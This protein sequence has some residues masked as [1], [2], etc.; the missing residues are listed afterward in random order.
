[1]HC[2][3]PDCVDALIPPSNNGIVNG[4]IVHRLL[5]SSVLGRWASGM[6]AGRVPPPSTGSSQCRYSASKQ[7]E[8]SRRRHDRAGGQLR[9]DQIR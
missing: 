5:R 8:V 3:L 6:I 9:S 7:E 2:R 1:M 4:P